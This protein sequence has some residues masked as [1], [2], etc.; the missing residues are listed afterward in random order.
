MANLIIA[1]SAEED[2]NRIV[3]YITE[4]LCNPEAADSL[5]DSIAECYDTLELMPSSF[6]FCGDPILRADDYHQVDLG[7]YV[8]IYRVEDENDI[9]RIVHYY[10]ETQDFISQLKATL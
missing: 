1:P 9:V 4:E 6:P 3:D 5:L 8:M 2:L 7:G 10:H